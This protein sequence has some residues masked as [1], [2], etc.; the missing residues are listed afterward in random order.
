MG[1]LALAG[2]VMDL[3]LTIDSLVTEFVLPLGLP[4]PEIDF[5]LP[6]S[7]S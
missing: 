6:V 5:M 3:L 1:S 2:A 4:L 7:F